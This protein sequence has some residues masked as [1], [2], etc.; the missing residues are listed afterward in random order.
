VTLN[1]QQQQ[2][3]Q[4]PGMIWRWAVFILVFVAANIFMAW[5]THQRQAEADAREA[6]NRALAAA[7]APDATPTPAPDSPEAEASPDAE[8]PDAAEP[9]AESVRTVSVA[10]APTTTVATPLVEVTF[11]QAGAVPLSWRVLPSRYVKAVEDHDSRPDG[12]IELVPQV[13][14]REGRSFPLQL[15]GATAADFNRCLFDVERETTAEGET[16]RFVSPEIDGVRM[17]KTFVFRNDSFLV[18]ATV[19]FVNGGERTRLG[20]SARGFGIGWLG[21]FMEAGPVDRLGG[22]IMAVVCSDEEMNARHLDEDDEPLEF[23]KD[24]AWAGQEKKYFA[25]LLVPHPDNPPAMA[26]ISVRRRDVTDEYSAKGVAAPMSVELVHPGR[27][28]APNE[29]FALKYGLFVGPK[30]YTM[31]RSLEVPAVA[32]A[33]P[34]SDVVF[35]QIWLGQTWIRSISILQ[36]RLLHWVEAHIGN[37]GLAIIALVLIVKTLLYPLSHWAIKAQA[38]SMAEQARIK[39]DMQRINEKFKD[40]PQRKGQEIMKLYREHGI[41]PLG[42]MRGC[43]PALLQMPIFIAL[44]VLL[45]ESV[46]LR[47]QSFLWVRNLTA[48]DQLFPFGFTLPLLGWYSFNVLPVLMAGTQYISSKMM[49]TN[50]EDPTQRQMLVMMPIMFTIFMYNMPAGL[51]LYWTVQNVWTIGQTVLTKRYVATHDAGEAHGKKPVGRTTAA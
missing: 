34:L 17:T 13:V 35:G 49:M 21:G 22:Q 25:A 10:D 8:R 47:G 33:L 15:S 16:V 23:R 6:E 43:V 12:S 36:L 26:E 3:P 20:D 30:D 41:N 4:P 2:Q 11:T 28:L 50:V 32:G 37:W 9:V 1:P 46:E 39:P 29:R 42:A 24:V 19:E 45:A 31:L 44:Y 5:R 40:D 51:M 38:R 48:P 7:S 27:E 18:D 14:E